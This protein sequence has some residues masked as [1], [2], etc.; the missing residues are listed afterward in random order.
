MFIYANSS[1]NLGERKLVKRIILRIALV[2]IV[3]NVTMFAFSIHPANACGIVGDLNG[4]G[5]VNMDDLFIVAEAYGSYLG[6]P[7]WNSRADING[8]D[9][10]NIVDLF[11]IA[12]HF[13]E[14]APTV[15]TAT[16]AIYPQA[17]NLRSKGKWIAAHIEL[18]EG[19]NLSDIDVSTI[20]L[21][22]TIP[23]ELTPIHIGD[24][25]CDGIPD[26][27]VKFERQK[28]IDLILENYQSARKFGMVTLTVA[29]EIAECTFQG[30]D[31][32]KIIQQ[33]CC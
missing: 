1:L 27:M 2:L 31:N 21:N 9:E 14:T 15:I 19:Y 4:D 33:T 26:L 23:V 7:R 20:M 12:K 8:D 22:D 11:L 6:H 17:L 28:M 16:V 25:D 32:I 3:F 30:S 13:G 24:C 10:V 29:G 18:S 5:T